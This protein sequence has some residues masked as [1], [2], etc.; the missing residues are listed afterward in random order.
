MSD[1][2][3][4]ME[5]RGNCETFSGQKHGG[6]T[7]LNLLATYKSLKPSK[8]TLTSPGTAERI[9]NWAGGVQRS[10]MRAP[11]APSCRG[12]WGNPPAPPCLFTGTYCHVMLPGM[13]RKDMLH[14]L[15]VV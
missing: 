2:S 6:K 13:G 10:H 3:S 7:F 15:S 12:V 9:L 8:E 11:E 5:T 1:K 14:K 4:K